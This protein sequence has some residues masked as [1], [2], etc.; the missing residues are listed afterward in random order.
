MRRT[1]EGRSPPAEQSVG[2]EV[3]TNTPGPAL[4]NRVPPPTESRQNC[5]QMTQLLL[6]R[7]YHG[8]PH[9]EQCQ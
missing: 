5:W 4:S 2:R 3:P 1:A 8:P 9:G 7:C 6:S